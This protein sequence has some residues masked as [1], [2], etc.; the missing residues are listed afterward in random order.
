MTLTGAVAD[1]AAPAACVG[2][3]MAAGA[4]TAGAGIASGTAGAAPDETILP[5]DF[6]ADG[7]GVRDR[8]STGLRAAV[9]AAA[10]VG[11]GG[12]GAATVRGVTGA[13]GAST[14]G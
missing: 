5:R 1:G 13:A 2:V 7:A 10:R 6:S 9:A 12:V 4:G 11:A 3:G 14:R 8:P